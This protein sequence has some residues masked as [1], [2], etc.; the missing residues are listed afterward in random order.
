SHIECGVGLKPYKTWES[1]RTKA[2]LIE[3]MDERL[4]QIPGLSIGFSQPIIDM[5]MDQIAGSHSDLAVK[6]YGDD[7]AQTRRV[8]EQIEQVVKEI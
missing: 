5:V 3:A 1:G 7:L 4:K 6:I 8:A 2:E